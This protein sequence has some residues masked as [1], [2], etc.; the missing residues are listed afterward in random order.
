[1]ASNN[2]QFN[3][4]KYVLALITLVLLTAALTFLTFKGARSHIY[5]TVVNGTVTDKT[6]ESRYT[7][8][9]TSSY[10]DVYTYTVQPASGGSEY[11][12][13]LYYQ[14]DYKVGDHIHVKIY[15]GHTVPQ[16]LDKDF[17]I[18]TAFAVF[19]WAA[20]GLMLLVNPHKLEAGTNIYQGR[21]T[22]YRV[23]I[24][25]LTSIVITVMLLALALAVIGNF[26]HG[27][28]PR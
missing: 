13:E 2:S 25:A 14:N 8:Y 23:I 21:S 28:P 11:K 18:T 9:R 20:L 24:I 12:M 10:M 17:L 27:S 6:Y 19:S 16:G 26:H 4:K 3:M 5:G 7:D 22:T 15:Q 1:M